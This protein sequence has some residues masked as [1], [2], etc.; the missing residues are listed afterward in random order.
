[1]KKFKVGD[2]VVQKST[3]WLKMTVEGYDDLGLVICKWFDLKENRWEQE[4]FPEETLDPAKRKSPRR[5]EG[6]GTL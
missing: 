1:M 3:T 6:H 2:V 5:V 4:I